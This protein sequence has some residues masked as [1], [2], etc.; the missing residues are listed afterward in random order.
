MTVSLPYLGE[1]RGVCCS[2]CNSSIQ[3]EHLKSV[4][5]FFH[6]ATSFDNNLI[7]KYYNSN[8]TKHALKG[9]F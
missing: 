9:L 3:V 4:P 6:N 2:W 1:I 5:L 8:L 7:I